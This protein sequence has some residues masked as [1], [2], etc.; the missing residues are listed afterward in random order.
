MIFLNLPGVIPNN[1]RHEETIVQIA[2]SLDNLS[3]AVSYIFDCIDK[4]LSEN[5][6]R[7]IKKIY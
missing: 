7:Y 4:R 3:D 2:E 5:T 1:L 6:Q